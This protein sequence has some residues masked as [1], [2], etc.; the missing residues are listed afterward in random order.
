M[1][2]DGHLIGEVVL[3]LLGG[4]VHGDLL[5]LDGEVKEEEP[6]GGIP[7][8]RRVRV[9]LHVLHG[10]VDIDES[11]EV[12]EVGRIGG[13]DVLQGSLVDPR[14][15]EGVLGGGVVVGGDGT[16]DKA[17]RNLGGQ[18]ADL[19]DLLVYGVVI[20]SGG[21]QAVGGPGDETLRAVGQGIVDSEL[22]GSSGTEED[23]PEIAGHTAVGLASVCPHL[24][25]VELLLVDGLSCLGSTQEDV[26]SSSVRSP[27]W[28][29]GPVLEIPLSV[30]E[31]FHML[32]FEFVLGCSLGGI[33]LL[34]EELYER[35]ALFIVLELVKHLFFNRSDDIVHHI[36]PLLV[37]GSKGVLFR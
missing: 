15:E 30:F 29:G 17:H 1:K 20:D 33:S 27:A 37:A 5:G 34:P 26:D 2:G 21:A 11:L 31:A 35:I 4:E 32:I 7:K 10:H 25:G 22:S 24:H 16:G 3:P 13:V 18:G 28:F 19:T 8:N 36:H 14:Q 12:G 6:R 9:R 23:H